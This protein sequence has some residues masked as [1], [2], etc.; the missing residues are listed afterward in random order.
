MTTA[1]YLLCPGPVRSR[2]DGQVHHV[3]AAQLARLYRVPMDECVTLPRPGNP[4]ATDLILSL[5]ERS[6]PGGDLIRLHPR[7]DGDYRL[8]AP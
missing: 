2:T 5:M 8:P 7:F 1:R 3:S 6:G 4:C